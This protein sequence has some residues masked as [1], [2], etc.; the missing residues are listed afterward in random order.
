MPKAARRRCTDAVLS[1][2]KAFQPWWR[3]DAFSPIRCSRPKS[4]RFHI[5]DPFNRFAALCYLIIAISIISPAVILIASDFMPGA[6]HH[7]WKTDPMGEV[8]RSLLEGQRRSALA[9][10]KAAIDA[11]PGG[12][13]L[14]RALAALAADSAPAEAR[15]AYHKLN[16]LGLATHAGSS[17]HAALLARLHD[18]TGSKAILSNLPKEAQSISH[19]QFA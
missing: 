16:S 2:S 10:L 3:D 17:G 5:G 7:D 11:S 19:A 4:L 15:R 9:S 14:L 13:K 1:D 6:V 8:R 12:A 18:F